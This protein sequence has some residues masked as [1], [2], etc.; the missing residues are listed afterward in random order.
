[1]KLKYFFIILLSMLS[2]NSV[3]SQE[4]PT[5]QNFHLNTSK[6]DSKWLYGIAFNNS[7]TTLSG[8]EGL[9]P[10]IKPSLGFH[11]RVEYYISPN[12]GIS[13]G[14][15]FQ[16]RGFGVINLD[17]NSSENP[18]STYRQRFRIG[19]I[20]V[21]I[22]MVIRQNNFLFNDAKLSVGVGFVPSYVNVGKDVFNSVE[23]GFH[24]IHIITDRYK[25]F[26]AP[27]R[28]G[29]GLDVNASGSC[30]FRIH[31]NADFGLRKV[32]KAT[33]GSFS[34]RHRLYGLELSCLF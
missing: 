16:Q 15:G 10:F 34:G 5:L 22:Q 14:I 30:L 12:I 6:F 13:S 23:D 32:Y 33:D 7:W 17:D 29:G 19:N 26:D 18:D 20:S 27:L 25:R 8:L 24:D 1:M 21:P 9:T 2:F 11:A 28:I 31:F 4:K 3:F